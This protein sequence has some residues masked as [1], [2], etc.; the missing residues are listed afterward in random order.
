MVLREVNMM[1]TIKEADTK[2]LIKKA[3]FL[4][5]QIEAGLSHIFNSI[6]AKKSKKVAPLAKRD[7]L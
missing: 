4:L 3:N 1:K 5:D 6:K 2:R 7:N